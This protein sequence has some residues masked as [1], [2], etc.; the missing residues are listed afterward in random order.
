MLRQSTETLGTKLYWLEG[1]VSLGRQST[2]TLGTKIYWLEGTVTLEITVKKTEGQSIKTNPK[3]G[4]KG[5][6]TVP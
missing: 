6:L 4:N 5:I 3:G 1:T 2:E